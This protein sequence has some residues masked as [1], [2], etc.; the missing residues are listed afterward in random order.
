MGYKR[1]VWPTGTIIKVQEVTWEE[2]QEMPTKIYEEDR[3]GC[4]MRM[5]TTDGEWILAAQ[6]DN[7][8]GDLVPWK[9]T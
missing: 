4:F 9:V 3:G 1:D 5:T 7:G 6:N 2:Q 8:H